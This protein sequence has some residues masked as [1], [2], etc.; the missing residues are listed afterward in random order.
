MTSIQAKYLACKVTRRS[1][2]GSTQRIVD[3]LAN[4]KFFSKSNLLEAALFS[5]KSSVQIS[6]VNYDNFL[7][8]HK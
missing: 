4:T 5:C 8:P 6:G 7:S 3:N 1:P 2:V